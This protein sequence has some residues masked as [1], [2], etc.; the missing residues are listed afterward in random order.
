MNPTGT[1]ERIVQR[2]GFD[3]YFAWTNEG[4]RYACASGPGRPP[5]PRGV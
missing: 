3:Y 2:C 1:F 4:E 5:L